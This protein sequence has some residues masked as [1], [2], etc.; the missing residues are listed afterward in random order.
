MKKI[1]SIAI[2]LL[3]I[4]N[5]GI[6]QVQM[7]GWRTHFSY[8]T[9]TKISQSDNKIFAISEGSLFSIDKIDGSLEFYSKLSGLNG[10]NISQIA[11]D[12]DNKI[13]LI[14][15]KDGNIDFLSSDGVKNLPDFYNKQMSADKNIHHILIYNNT[16]YLSCSFGIM[17]LN[18]VKMEIQ[19]TY[20]IGNN[21]TDVDV[22]NT[23][24]YNGR[25][26]AV[27]KNNIYSADI[28]NPQI[29]SYEF[30]TKMSE[31]P[32]NGDIESLLS[33]GSKLILLRNK[34]LYAFENN[35]WTEID[36]SI[37]F[38]NIK[39][40]ENY[41][42]AF[43]DT[44][45]YFY[46]TTLSQKNEI[47]NLIG[48]NDGLFDTRS[49]KFW[50]SGDER[51]VAE[52]K[53]EDIKFYKPSGPAV[54]I[55]YTMKFA[56]KKLFVLQGGRW[57][58]Q[59]NR[60]GVV[61]MYEDNQWKN[62]NNQSITANTNK[63][64][65]DF[66][67]IAIDPN[68]NKHFFV[69][70]YGN[71]VYEFKNDEF[72]Q[73][74]NFENSTIET[75]FPNN[76]FYM[77]VD[78]G[79]Y[80]SDGNIW[81]A[82]T[83]AN[84]SLKYYK[85]DGTWGSLKHNKIKDIAT[86]GKVLISKKNPNQKWLL[87]IRSNPGV[88][89][90]DD[91]GTPFNESDDKVIFKHLFNYKV[92]NE[93]RQIIPLFYYSIAEDNDGV[94]WIG[95]D[96]GPIVLYNPEEIMN[97]DYLC[98]R[99]TIPRNDGTNTGDFLL[100]KEKIKC[101]AIDGANRKWI[102]TEGSGLY[103]LSEDGKETIHHFTTE[104]SPLTSNEILSLAINSITGEIFIG[105]GSGLVSYQSDSAISEE[106]FSNLHIYP[107]PVRENYN[108]LITITGLV[109]KSQVKITDISG[110]LI[111]ETQSNGSIAT[112]DGKNKYGQKVSTGVY[113][114]ICTSADGTQSATKKILII[115]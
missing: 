109:E 86:L 61:M 9:I 33:F 13:M 114:A 110:N 102:G 77:R 67:D 74:Y 15:Y 94:I 71:G 5:L 60:P 3:T 101:I 11:Y 58:S 20:Y 47:K 29:I 26:Y 92:N 75:I 30:W 73:W 38:N 90:I 103:L 79:T 57:A 80:D 112:W 54:N 96:Q 87:S 70:S 4:A 6:A 44:K 32:G 53:S 106:D 105:T 2:T 76:Y 25:I 7:G 69:S 108:G 104:N 27:S 40:F 42:L 78:G 51:G 31:L 22:L 14:A 91:N 82:N 64:A 45:S 115:N 83:S 107:N 46:D 55:P 37:N 23:T 62:I 66:M 41:L 1:L 59:Y 16:A 8:N 65:N 89:V 28:S 98:T 50:F 111:V 35:Q 85:N 39:S 100:E 43:S 68:D 21:S 97:D 88:I 34:K 56:G 95:T 48:L 49:E 12:S 10:T 19:D 52:Y 113:L 84:E 81:F 17:T 24:L 99:I 63:P 93:I 72:H 18:M 36:N